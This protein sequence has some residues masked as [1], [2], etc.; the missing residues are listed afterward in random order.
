MIYLRVMAA[1]VGCS[2]GS[3]VPDRW[4]LLARARVAASRCV[5]GW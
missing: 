5:E 2:G 1:V 3:G 4:W